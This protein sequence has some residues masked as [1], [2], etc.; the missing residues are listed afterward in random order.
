[1]LSPLP[2]LAATVVT[3]FAGDLIFLWGPISTFKQYR[4]LKH[5]P[6]FECYYTFYGLTISFLALLSKKV[7]WKERAF[8][9]D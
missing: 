2:V 5:F 1:V 6:L 4:L 7:V 3:K 8:R 9:G